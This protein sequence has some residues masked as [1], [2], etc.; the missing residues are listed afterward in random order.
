M[1]RPATVCATVLLLV[2]NASTALGADGGYGRIDGDVSWQLDLG[3]G[4]GDGEPGAVGML[5]FRYLQTAGV[6]GTWMWHP[7]EDPQPRWTGA[8]GV[9]L[10]PLFLPRFLKDMETGPPRFDLFLDSLSL[11]LGAV[12]ADSGAFAHRGPGVET[13]LAI[14]LPLSSQAS[15]LWLSASGS[16]RFSHLHMSGSNDDTDRALVWTLTL[17]W[18]EFFGP[19]IVDVGDA[20]AP[21]F[22]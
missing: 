22:D 3:G 14:G 6:Y 19:G 15:G 21:R 20:L 7:S 13:G 8:F 9:E 18:Q 16:I 5:A 11:R 4:S 12:I 1:N 2:L 17:G 10:R